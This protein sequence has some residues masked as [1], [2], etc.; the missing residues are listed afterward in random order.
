M[1]KKYMRLPL[2][3]PA[4]AFKN[5]TGLWMPLVNIRVGHDHRQ[6]PRFPAVVDSGS[7][8]C[9]FKA[10]VAAYLGIDYQSGIEDMIGGIT[11]TTPEPV[12]FHKVRIFVETDWIIDVM[13]GFCKKL[14]VTGILGRNGFFDNFCVR[15]DHSTKPQEM[16]ITKIEK[17]Q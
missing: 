8:W 15:F 5:E 16:E 3:K 9:L 13:A 10:D 11:Q 17:I 12:Y 7:P 6:S 1:K 4:A 2:D 14:S